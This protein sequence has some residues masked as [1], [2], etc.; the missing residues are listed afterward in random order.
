MPPLPHLHSFVLSPQVSLRDLRVLISSGE[1][2]PDSETC[3]AAS[4]GPLLQRIAGLSTL[5]SNLRAVRT[6][7]ISCARG[8]HFVAK[9][10]F[11]DCSPR[12]GGAGRPLF[13]SFTSALTG[14]AQGGSAGARARGRLRGSP[15][16]HERSSRQRARSPKCGRCLLKDL[17]LDDEMRSHIDKGTHCFSRRAF[18]R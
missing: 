15:P 4:S 14:V 18:R 1:G 10:G 17:G 8:S 5:L 3:S 12:G 13:P 7:D 2:G 6:L 11:C 16:T 9:C